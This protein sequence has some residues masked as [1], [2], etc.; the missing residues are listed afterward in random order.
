[1][2]RIKIEDLPVMEDLDENRAKS[3]SGGGDSSLEGMEEFENPLAGQ[4][5]GD[6]EFENPLA[7]YDEP[8]PEIRK[9]GG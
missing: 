1:M 2:S 5:K 7:G 9:I 6:T 3:I 4:E 8:D